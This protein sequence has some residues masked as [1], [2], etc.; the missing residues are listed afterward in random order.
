LNIEKEINR[1][2][3]LHKNGDLD[4][5]A[6]IYKKILSVQPNNAD[7]LHLLG[8]AYFQTGDPETAQKLIGGAIEINPSNHNFHNNLGN[9][10]RDLKRYVEAAISYRH[11][12][13][14][15]P[16]S[17]DAQANLAVAL[18]DLKQFDEAIEACKIAID[19][20]PNLPHPY[21]TLGNIYCDQMEWE[22]AEETFRIA[23][24][25][26]PYPESFNN[27]GNVLKDLGRLD[28]AVFCYQNAVALNSE[29]AEAFN[30][31]GNVLKLL[32]QLEEA[33]E[34]YDKAIGIWPEFSEAHF[35]LGILFKEFGHL[36]AAEQEYRLAFD[37]D[38][39]NYSAKHMLSAL[40]GES[41]EAA[42]LEYVE[43]LFDRFA[44]TFDEELINK[45]SYST[46]NL[47]KELITTEIP[48]DVKF[49][50]VVDLGCGTGLSGEGIR[51]LSDC[52][53][54]IDASKKM[55]KV[56]EE[57]NIYD[58]LWQ[59]EI[60]EALSI[61][62]ETYDLFFAA[63]V[64]VYLGNLEPVFNAVRK[65]AREEA[66]FVFSTESHSGDEDFN[67]RITGRF[68]H[69]RQYIKRI[70]QLTGFIIE[71]AKSANIRKD[72]GKWINGDLFILKTKS[73]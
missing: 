10:L 72:K 59:G 23:L 60:V 28:E 1:A 36:A 50:N 4:E 13:E 37:L 71:E 51:S 64:F 57:K 58:Q 70:S 35:N 61:S 69:S 17:I 43:E 38:P 45:L 21:N 29:Y 67:L 32:N 14:L 27:L 18:R 62:Q 5:A 53:T 20:N 3:R 63:D 2:V 73:T 22:K 56:A 46:P 49:Q 8:V 48:S 54:G 12:L 9:A 66:L 11:A 39:S 65:Q 40:S 16:R 33:K 34:A 44:P 47:L 24:E 25:I 7:A 6:E 52:L 19:L 42:S 30:N 55:L 41:I 15:E 31:L 68:A 26:Q